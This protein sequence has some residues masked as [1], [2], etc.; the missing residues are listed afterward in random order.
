MFEHNRSLR[1]LER[2]MPSGM[3]FFGFLLILFGIIGIL[4]TSS[5]ISQRNAST[6]NRSQAAGNNQTNLPNP[7]DGCWYIRTS[8]CGGPDCQPTYELYCPPMPFRVAPARSDG[9]IIWELPDVALTAD[10]LSI[11]LADGRAFTTR[12]IV[13]RIDS[14]P[15]SVSGSNYTTLESTW[16]ENG[17]EM[18]LYIY[19]YKNPSTQIWYTN[20]IR[21][22]NGEVNGDWI[23]FRQS[24]DG[25]SSEYVLSAPMGTAYKNA[26]TVTLTSTDPAG[27]A[28]LRLRNMNLQA[29]LRKPP[30]CAEIGRR[31]ADITGDERVDILDVTAVTS[32]FFKTGDLDADLTCDQF[33]DLNDY[34]IL[35]QQLRP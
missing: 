14:D 15:I 29:F 20:E 26:G 4:T 11:E 23:T 7:P 16:Y 32:N 6:E 13:V 17:V 25:T 8:T 19:L 2:A 24:P 18:R 1:R 22:Y 31:P 12:D 10:S 5:E 27:G 30:Y 21:V 9:K 3:A 28:T 34:T 33:V 35:I